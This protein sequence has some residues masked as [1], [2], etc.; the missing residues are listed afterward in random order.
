M[1]NL[2]SWRSERNRNGFALVGLLVVIALGCGT[3]AFCDDDAFENQVKAD[4]A[5]ALTAR[6]EAAL[7][8]VVARAIEYDLNRG[9][10]DA[11]DEIEDGIEQALR[12]AGVAVTEATEDAIEIAI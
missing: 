3:Q 5:N 11:G 1:F 7:E 4:V 10:D 6:N 2:S 9:D 8:A 12:V